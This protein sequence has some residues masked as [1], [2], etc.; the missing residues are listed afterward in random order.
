M[1]AE[2]KFN[3]NDK[4]STMYLGTFIHDQLIGNKDYV[5]NNIILNIDNPNC[6]VLTI[7]KETDFEHIPNIAIDFAGV[8]DMNIHVNPE[9][10]DAHIYANNICTQ[11]KAN[12]HEYEDYFDNTNTFK[13]IKI[14]DGYNIFMKYNK[15]HMVFMPRLWFKSNND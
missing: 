8:I 2:I 3:T 10:V 14:Q 1:L 4:D 7:F 11:L 5:D 6:I 12:Y 13:E 15:I 9:N